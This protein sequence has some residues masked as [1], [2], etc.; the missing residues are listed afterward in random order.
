MN[1]PVPPT[2]K[3]VPLAIFKAPALLKLPVVLKV[4]PLSKLKVPLAAFVLKFINA[5][6]P[7]WSMILEDVPLRAMFPAL[8]TMLA[9]LNWKVQRRCK[10]LRS[11]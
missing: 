4:R 1:S 9:P 10:S 2:V 11:T 7:L 5:L 6:F 8:V 3:L